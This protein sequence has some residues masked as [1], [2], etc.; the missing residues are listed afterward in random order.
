M[1]RPERQRRSRGQ[2]GVVLLVVL[3]LVVLAGAGVL[4]EGLTQAAARRDVRDEATTRALAEARAALLG[5]AAANPDLPG[6]LPF[7]DRN[8]DGNYDGNGD[9][10]P[11]TVAVS[12]SHLL[13]RLPWGVQ[14]GG[15]CAG[16]AAIG[17]NLLRDAG[18]EPLW[19]AVSRNL[20]RDS[21][22]GG[23]FLEPMINSEWAGD[24]ATLAWRDTSLSPSDD[25]VEHAPYPWLKVCDKDGTLLS[26]RVA[27]VILAPG[28]PLSGQDRSGAA[29]DAGAYLDR[30]TLP[31]AVSP[32]CPT[33]YDNADDSD[34]TFIVHPDT[35]HD[36]DAAQ[37]F[38]DRLV[39]V[40]VEQLVT[41]VERRVAGEAAEA[42]RRYRGTYGAYPWL[43]P[44]ADPSISDFKSVPGTR[45]G[46]LAVHRAGETFATQFSVQ[47]SIPG[48]TTSAFGTVTPADLRSGPPG[49]VSV[50]PGS[51]EWQGVGEV[52]HCGGTAV[53]QP[54]TLPPPLSMVVRRTY[55][56]DLTYTA[57]ANPIVH[58]PTATTR[59]TRD[60][61][62][63]G[64]T[65]PPQGPAVVGI[66]DDVLGVPVGFGFLWVTT[67]QTAS[68][69]TAG[70]AYD[71]DVP[72]EL[73][74]WFTGNR[75]QRYL[76][77][78]ESQGVVPGG[79]GGCGAPAPP[80][81]ALPDW[82]PA[83]SAP[84]ALLV[85]AGPA[86]PA[87]TRPAATPTAYFEGENADPGDDRFEARPA[88][89]VPF[90]DQ[91]RVVSP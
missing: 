51:C 70:I 87:Q 78:A 18:G 1:G 59:R 34:S 4:I 24:P 43:S 86:L 88:P 37:A 48:G 38:D 9:C 16:D 73:P 79:A 30:V 65:Y 14:Q 58:P 63:V 25:P 55:T 85:A 52:A 2:R 31:G 10:L 54:F 82:Y 69:T 53:I 50:P 26:D 21:T 67:P 84:E 12:P 56:F 20:V 74:Q 33:S 76:Y 41:A 28:P 83:L 8:G 68:L 7:P 81:L 39:Y 46:H 47:W 3:V 35:R 89:P 36:P 45:E 49:G 27:F 6:L 42:L 57:N 66:V 71:L 5:W 11:A 72:A 90:N 44:F 61:P 80:C 17:N 91:T 77:A 19:Y 62:L 22:G 15:A 32:Q 64:G 40:T 13:G 23:S 75:W 60:V 29:P